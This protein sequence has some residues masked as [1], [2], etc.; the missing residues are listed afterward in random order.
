MSI[1]L[2][3]PTLA[4]VVDQHRKRLTLA[5]AHH[6]DDDSGALTAYASSCRVA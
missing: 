5:I 3:L 6:K 1:N 2:P 4:S